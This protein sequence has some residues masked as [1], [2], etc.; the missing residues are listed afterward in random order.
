MRRIAFLLA[1][2]TLVTAPAFAAEEGA[3]AGAATGAAVGGPVGAAVGAG[4]GHAATGPDRDTVV[5]R[6]S[7]C[8][9]TTVRKE[10]EVGDSKTVHRE[11]CD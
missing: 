10:N 2:A 1:A 7:G 6:R 9:H 5:K 4:V 11:E 8:S 3:A